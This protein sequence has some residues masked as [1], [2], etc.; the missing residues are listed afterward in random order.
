MVIVSICS[1]RPRCRAAVTRPD[2]MMAEG[3]VRKKLV[4]LDCDEA[5]GSLLAEIRSCRACAAHLEHGPRPIVHASPRARILIVGQAP[6]ARVHASGVPWDDASGTRLREWLGITPDVFYDESRIA[7]VPMGY[8]YPG[9]G[10]SG[11]LPPRKE[12][13]DL[14][15]DRL[16]MSM[17][18]IR[19]TLLV[20]QYAQRH[21]LG[22][23][24]RG[25]L[26]GTVQA[27]REY[28]PRFFPLPH[29][30]PRNQSWWMRRPWFEEQLLP[31]LR[32]RFAHALREDPQA[33]A[34]R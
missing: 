12:C 1:K 19:L 6:G 14:W 34:P 8:C 24:W 2:L 23:R 3:T 15:L 30:S 31:E 13:A 26:T 7:I 29:P 11:D 25:S 22:A 27:W 17:P 5:F 18:D 9:K 16:L 33:D 21:F 32:E 28:Q 20:G 10:R 4:A